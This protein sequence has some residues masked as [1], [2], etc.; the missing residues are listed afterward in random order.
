[1][2][3]QEINLNLIP[4]AIPPRVDVVQYDKGSRTIKIHLYS[5]FTPFMVPNGA[6]V[7]VRGT[8]KDGTGFEYACEYNGNIVTFDITS[9]MTIFDG[10]LKTDLQIGLGE[11]ILATAPFYLIIGKSALEAETVISETELP[12]I[13]QLIEKATASAATVSGVVS[14]V[15]ASAQASA[16][17]AQASANSAQ[18]AANKLQEINDAVVSARADLTGFTV[19]GTMAQGA[20]SITLESSQID[21][22]ENIIIT[23]YCN[24]YGYYPISI[25]TENGRCTLTFATPSE[26]NTQVGIEVKKFV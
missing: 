21:T 11:E 25:L 5:G 8:K 19:H 24:V 17:S 15:N 20:T 23:P 12:A 13:E 4:N 3:T 18:I 9:Q 16:D 14:Q 6:I 7:M 22:Q 26:G 2:I 1:M 10:E